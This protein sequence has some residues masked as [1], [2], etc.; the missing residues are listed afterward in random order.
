MISFNVQYCYFKKSYF[1][2]VKKNDAIG[3][4]NVLIEFKPF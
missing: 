2:L 1:N 3:D 4:D